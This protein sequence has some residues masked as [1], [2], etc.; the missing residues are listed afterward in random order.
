MSSLGKYPSDTSELETSI[1]MG[2]L[3]LALI[4]RILA[5]GL[6]SD[7]S[8]LFASRDSSSTNGIGVIGLDTVTKVLC[9]NEICACSCRR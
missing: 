6:I 1:E 4:L 8:A 3:V 5:N 2:C 7:L 9:L